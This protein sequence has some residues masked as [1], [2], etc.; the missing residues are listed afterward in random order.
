MSAM[1]SRTLL[2]DGAQPASNETHPIVAAIRNKLHRVS[3][4]CGGVS[5]MFR[6]VTLCPWRTL[7]ELSSIE[8]LGRS[9][10]EIDLYQRRADS[11]S[12]SVDDAPALIKQA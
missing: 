7:C 6:L 10:Y 5:L 4:D 8:H 11:I 3:S 2:S 12:A 9:G 1:L